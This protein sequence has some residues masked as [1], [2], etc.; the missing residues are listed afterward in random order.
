L[1]EWGLDAAL[2]GDLAATA[3][4]ALAAEPW[5][6]A[7]TARRRLAEVPLYAWAVEDGTPT[8]VRGVVDL[9]FEEEDGWV[10]V[11]YK[12]TALRREY[13]EPLK[14][15]YAPQVR[16]Y[17]RLWEAATGTRVKEIG[18]LFVNT[19]NRETHYADVE[20]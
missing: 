2:A 8:V 19:G 20:R 15:Y 9:A 13:Y 7:T 6:R 5:R 16:E 10:L 3:A 18:F 12:T 14:A 4:G 1:R 17:A 11:D